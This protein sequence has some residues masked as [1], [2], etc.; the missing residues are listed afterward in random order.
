MLYIKK[1]GK[2]FVKERVVDIWLEK[3]LRRIINKRLL[4]LEIIT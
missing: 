1:I 3:Y 4:I 2:F